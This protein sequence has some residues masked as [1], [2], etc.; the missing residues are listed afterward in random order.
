MNQQPGRTVTKKEL[1]HRIAEELDQTKVVVRGVIQKFLD[2]I[3]EELARGNR[4]EFREFGVFE[5]RERSQR[6]AQNPRTL[7][8]VVV[9][10]RRVVRFKVGRAMRDLTADEAEAPA[11][12]VKTPAPAV[13]RPEPPPPPVRPTP[14]KPPP[15]SPGSPF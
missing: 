11:P 14:P 3:V 1:V 10:P 8:K 13:A 4:L 12:K 7:S 15:T 6:R 2:E 9:P 5:V